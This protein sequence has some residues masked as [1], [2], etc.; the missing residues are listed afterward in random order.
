MTKWL[1]IIARGIAPNP[2]TEVLFGKKGQMAN[3]WGHT[4]LAKNHV[5]FQDGISDSLRSNSHVCFCLPFLDVN[6]LGS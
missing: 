5:I 6:I 3:H 2:A 4:Y 1:K